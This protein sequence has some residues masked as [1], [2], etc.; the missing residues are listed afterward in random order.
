MKF[1][2]FSIGFNLAQIT[3]LLAG[4]H[5]HWPAAMEW[6]LNALSALNLNIDLFSPECTSNSFS[7]SILI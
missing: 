6:L 7:V 5:L 1:N 4:F 2:T 3:A